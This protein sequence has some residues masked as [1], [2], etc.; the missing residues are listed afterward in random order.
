[1]LFP[2]ETLFVIGLPES[3]SGSGCTYSDIEPVAR[4]E[5]EAQAWMRTVF[6]ESTST[7]T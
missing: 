7:T 6:F 2:F 5:R 4:T 1:M 3:L